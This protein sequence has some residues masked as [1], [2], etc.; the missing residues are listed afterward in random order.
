[1]T[2]T[3]EWM[4]LIALILAFCS[5][6][7]AL[8]LACLSYTQVN[9]KNALLKTMGVDPSAQVAG[10]SS[11]VTLGTSGLSVAP[12]KF[13]DA[14]PSTLYTPQMQIGQNTAARF[15]ANRGGNANKDVI[16]NANTLKTYE[17]VDFTPS[18]TDSGLQNNTVTLVAAGTKVSCQVIQSS[19]QSTPLVRVFGTVAFN[20]ANTNVFPILSGLPYAAAT[21][22]HGA[23]PYVNGRSSTYNGSNYE[24]LL[25][26]KCHVVGTT[27]YF[28]DLVLNGTNSAFTSGTKTN[29]QKLRVNDS[30]A[31]LVGDTATGSTVTISFDISYPFAANPSVTLTPT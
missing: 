9:D 1:M 5:G 13:Y 4:L 24:Q 23:V 11:I 15:A 16:N 26:S 31:F 6:V 2:G 20:T 7:A 17:I 25:G 29:T 3:R 19:G 18:I 10:A 22:T 12:A 14:A 21:R 8:V 30:S 28:E 27:L